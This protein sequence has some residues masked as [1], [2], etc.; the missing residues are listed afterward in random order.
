MLNEIIEYSEYTKNI[1]VK[2]KID[3]S[4]RLIPNI[5]NTTSESKKDNLV[6]LSR[7]MEI[8]ARYKLFN[9]LKYQNLTDSNGIELI[10]KTKENLENWFNY[11]VKEYYKTYIEGDNK[12]KYTPNEW[13][14]FCKGKLDQFNNKLF[15]TGYDNIIKGRSNNYRDITYEKIIS[16]AILKGELKEYVLICRYD[17][18]YDIY[19]KE[20]NKEKS[21]KLQGE[22][23]KKKDK[24]LQKKLDH[25]LKVV[26]AYLL[27]LEIDKTCS[28]YNNTYQCITKVDLANWTQTSSI[29]VGSSDLFKK[30]YHKNQSIFESYNPDGGIFKMSV[31]SRFL[32]EKEFDIVP[33]TELE[34]Y[35]MPK[36]CIIYRDMGS[37]KYL[38]EYES[39][40]EVLIQITKEKSAK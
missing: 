14:G 36:N 26:S 18:Y 29:Y 8:V 31:N 22:G 40:E 37:D 38:Y 5:F 6:G 33:I 17:W 7:A 34:N 24:N 12:R 3:Y 13:E 16:N 1:F 30:Y 32:E 11:W 19:I 21:V 15:P 25:I 27:A 10:E 2:N 35:D 28:A 4:P 20:D 23:I 39:K 9:E